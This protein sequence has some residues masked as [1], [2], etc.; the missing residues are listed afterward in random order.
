MK[1]LVDAQMVQTHHSDYVIT[2]IIYLDTKDM[3]PMHKVCTQLAL[4]FKPE[5]MR[6]LNFVIFCVG[7][8]VNLLVWRR[9]I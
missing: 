2:P 1:R 7:L 4:T 9:P 8:V 3:I 6:F 5:S